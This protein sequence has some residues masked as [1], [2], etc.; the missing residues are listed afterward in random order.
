MKFTHFKTGQLS[1]QSLFLFFRKRLYQA[2]IERN[3]LLYDNHCQK[4][5]NNL[6]NIFFYMTVF[7]LIY[8]VP[9]ENL[10]QIM[11]YL[12]RNNGQT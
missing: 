9:L 6:D 10:N 2:D 11:L 1:L 12:I 3:H 8:R 7:L 4:T 5:Q